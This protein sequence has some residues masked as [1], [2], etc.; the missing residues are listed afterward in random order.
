[1]GHEKYHQEATPYDQ[2][3]IDVPYILRAMMFF[4]QAGGPQY[5]GLSNDYQRFVDLTALLK[6]NRAILV[7]QAPQGPQTVPRHA[8]LLRDGQPWA[9][10]ACTREH[11]S[12]RI[13]AE[14]SNQ[15]SAISYQLSDATADD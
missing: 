15:L 7:A 9:A 12:L 10:R 8:E 5:T 4:D 1:M 2:S 3:S 14:M 11:L 13:S 6:A